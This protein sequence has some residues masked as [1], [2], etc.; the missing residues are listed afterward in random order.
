MYRRNRL[1]GQWLELKFE[2]AREALL[3]TNPSFSAKS[4]QFS[5][6]GNRFEN[7]QLLSNVGR[8]TL[9]SWGG[10]C[11]ILASQPDRGLVTT[12]L[13][14]EAGLLHARG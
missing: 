5:Q 7:I 4:N 8:E 6:P 2:F 3:M 10:A 11:G 12:P 14:I 9:S 13:R 1:L